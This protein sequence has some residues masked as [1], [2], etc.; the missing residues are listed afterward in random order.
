MNGCVRRLVNLLF[1]A[2]RFLSCFFASA[3]LSK[4]LKQSRETSVQR[5]A[6]VESMITLP[7]TLLP[8]CFLCLSYE[9]A[10]TRIV[11]CSQC[12]VL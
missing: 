10:V 7:F 12:T 3:E 11:I 6:I 5:V 1:L 9:N 2:A 8:P 4:P